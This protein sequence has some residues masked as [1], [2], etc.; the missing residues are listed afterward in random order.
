MSAV[1]VVLT[2]EEICG[3]LLVKAR[4]HYRHIAYYTGSPAPTMADVQR[5][6]FVKFLKLENRISDHVNVE[7]GLP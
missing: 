7:R 5:A 6:C 3:L 4:T 2:H 1:R